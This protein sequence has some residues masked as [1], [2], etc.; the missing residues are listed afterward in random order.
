MYWNLARISTPRK[1]SKLSSFSV[2]AVDVVHLRIFLSSPGD[3][4]NERVAARKI[5]NDL[6]HGHLLKNR[7]T[8]DVIAWDDEAAPT[9]M[10][11]ATTPQV[12]VN[13]Y[14]GR[15]RDCDLTVV[16]LWSRLG[17]PL[18]DEFRKLDGSRFASG[19]VWEFE[20]AKAAQR[21]VWLYRCTTKP[22]VEIDDSQYEE[23]RQQYQGVK[24]FFE[25]FDAADGSL[26]GGINSFDSTASFEDQ[27]KKHLEAF[28]ND[29]LTRSGSSQAAAPSA[30]PL[31]LAAL[32]ALRTQT[33]NGA[34]LSLSEES[35]HLIL[36]HAPRSLD[37]YRLGRIA[38]WSQTRYAIDKRFTPLTLLLDQGEQAQGTRWQ[39]QR[40]FSDLQAVLREVNEPAIV[41][42]GPPGCGKST[43]LRRLELDL[44][45]CALRDHAD[46]APSSV[47]LPLNSYRFLIE[48]KFSPREWIANEWARRWPGLDSFDVLLRQGK[49]VLLL[50]AV[51]EMPHAGI[52]DYRERIGAW[53]DFLI[54]LTRNA[55]GTRVVFNLP[56]IGL[57]R[58]AV[59]P[60]F[61]R[62]ARAH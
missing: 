24:K 53:R 21:P 61:T 18:P 46:G 20:D 15:P 52:D 29:R 50:D 57:Q 32:A 55:P 22:K 41:V 12:S 54:D 34:P 47:F 38:E 14:S 43:L 4:I 30:N 42:L 31:A 25:Q 1:S 62:A 23:K 2:Q 37:E 60:R 36:S 9:P 44:A 58:H 8:I 26:S 27:F 16:I 39:A 11:A 45:L 48:N 49:L 33:Q 19:T 3:V 59:R 6:P 10:D 17:T 13:R 56:R 35:V 40:Q 5:L 51:N 7:V 28:I